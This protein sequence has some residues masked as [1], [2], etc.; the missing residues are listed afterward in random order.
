MT[1][2]W[3]VKTMFL[4]PYC[5]QVWSDL[6]PQSY[7]T[8][9]LSLKKSFVLCFSWHRREV[10]GKPWVTTVALGLPHQQPRQPLHPRNPSLPRNGKSV[11]PMSLKSKGT[12]WPLTKY[13]FTYRTLNWSIEVKTLF[14]AAYSEWLTFKFCKVAILGFK[15]QEHCNH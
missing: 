9:S 3:C 10:Q 11:I 6:L 7:P 2:N 12:L 4:Q 5:T 13:T 1:R 15:S 8:L 14:R